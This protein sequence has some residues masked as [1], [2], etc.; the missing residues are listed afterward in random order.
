MPRP[1]GL[2]HP[3]CDHTFNARVLVIRQPRAGHRVLGRR[4]VVIRLVRHQ[5]CVAS[6]AVLVIDGLE[7]GQLAAQAYGAESSFSEPN[8]PGR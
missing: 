6:L 4:C 5:G 1:I 8:R 3:L 7:V 2:R